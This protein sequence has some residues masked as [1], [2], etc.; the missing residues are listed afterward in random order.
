M[1]HNNETKQQKYAR[2]YVTKQQTNLYKKDADNIS[3][4]LNVLSKLDVSGAR[5]L[6]TNPA[7]I[8]SL[9]QREN[10]FVCLYAMHA[11]AAV[12][13]NENCPDILNEMTDEDIA[14][15]QKCVSIAKQLPH[16][17]TK[18]ISQSEKER[19]ERKHS[20]RIKLSDDTTRAMTQFEVLENDVMLNSLAIYKK[21]ENE[22]CWQDALNGLQIL[23]D[24]I[25]TFKRQSK[26]QESTGLEE[27]WTI[28]QLA[29]K[30]DVPVYHVYNHVKHQILRS[31]SSLAR[32]I[33]QE[34]IDEMRNWFICVKEQG[35]YKRYVFRAKYFDEY[36]QVFT[37]RRTRSV[38]TKSKTQ[39]QNTKHSTQLDIRVMEVK[40]AAIIKLCTQ[41]EQELNDAI[42][43]RQ[44]VQN[45]IGQ[46]TD[47]DKIS[48]LSVELVQH[49]DSVKQKKQIVE[50]FK[51]IKSLYQQQQQAKDAKTSAEHALYDATKSLDAINAEIAAMLS[52]KQK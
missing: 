38:K 41:A 52:T 12:L 45:A 26:N 13:V 10:G 46:E 39:K 1:A 49:N 42:K 43:K 35:T 16:P 18:F 22:Q 47:D 27:I 14:I 48:E 40:L 6:V 9:I 7:D 31:H 4:T 21:V 24:A 34:S 51:T 15:L 30:L 33:G 17:H 8:R 29:E 5:K 36:K 11:I 25:A 28:Q 32:K 20:G 23:T 3:T 19:L 2:A 44:S 50:R 37:T